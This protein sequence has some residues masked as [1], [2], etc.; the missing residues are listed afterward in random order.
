MVLLSNVLVFASAR[1][2][3]ECGAYRYL[4]KPVSDEQLLEVLVETIQE[5]AHRWA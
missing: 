5:S 3:V 1:A 2:A 4:L